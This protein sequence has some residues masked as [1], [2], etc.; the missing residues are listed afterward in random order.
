MGP[1]EHDRPRRHH[2]RGREGGDHFGQ[3]ARPTQGRAR[4]LLPQ[5]ETPLGST[6]RSLPPRAGQLRFSEGGLDPH[7]RLHGVGP[8]MQLQALWKFRLLRCLAPA[9]WQVPHPPRPRGP[10]GD[11]SAAHPRG[12]RQAERCPHDFHGEAQGGVCK[13]GA[14]PR[15]AT[16]PPPQHKVSA[17]VLAAAAPSPIAQGLGL[18]APCSIFTPP[19]CTRPR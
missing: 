14:P 2:C 6:G 11:C 12:G 4:L 15:L 1:R 18:C 13:T 17:F 16:L 9:V 5:R 3:T 10:N 7:L 19:P 8:W